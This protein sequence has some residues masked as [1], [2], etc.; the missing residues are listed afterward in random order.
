M[1]SGVRSWSPA[2]RWCRAATAAMSSLTIVGPKQSEV[3]EPASE[4]TVARLSPSCSCSSRCGT[5]MMYCGSTPHASA[6]RVVEGRLLLVF[7]PPS[8]APARTAGRTRCRG[9][10]QS[11]CVALSKLSKAVQVQAVQGKASCPSQALS[12]LS[13]LSELSKLFQPC[14]SAEFREVEAAESV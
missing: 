7:A 11:A 12:K 10:R 3:S 8:S 6:Q 9:S 2:T 13:K 5:L 1:P 14:H 4:M